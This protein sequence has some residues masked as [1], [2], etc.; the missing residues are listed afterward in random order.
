MT[1]RELLTEL[2][3]LES[4]NTLSEI[5]EYD[6]STELDNYEN[7]LDYL[8]QR[9]RCELIQLIL[10]ADCISIDLKLYSYCVHLLDFTLEQVVHD[11]NI[12]Q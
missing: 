11:L 2:V 10:N 12:N 8:K 9:E 7:Y 3:R 5:D 4:A 6:T 1:Y